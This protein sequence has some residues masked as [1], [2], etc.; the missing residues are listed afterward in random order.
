[1]TDTDTLDALTNALGQLL[2]ACDYE[3]HPG[4]FLEGL[5]LLTEHDPD[6]ADAVR[7]A[8]TEANP[9]AAATILEQL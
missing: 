6:E 8:I 2:T 9:H 4:P 7:A 3:L 5:S 1:M